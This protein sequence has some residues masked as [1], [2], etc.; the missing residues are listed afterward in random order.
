MSNHVHI[1][2]KSGPDGLSQ[3]MRKLLT[4]YAICYNRRHQRCG[5][6]FQNRY[7]SI[8]CQESAYFQRLVSYIHLNPLRARLVKSIAE[9]DR[10]PWSGHSV[11]M[12]AQRN[13]WQERE[14]VLSQFGRTKR[15]ACKQYRHFLE[16][17]SLKGGQADLIG[18]GLIRS[19]GGWSEVKSH[20]RNEE[21][22]AFDERILGDG[23]FVESV[24]S[25]SKSDLKTDYEIRTRKEDAVRKIKEA[26]EERKVCLDHLRSGSRRP[27]VSALRKELAL[28]LVNEYGYS[29][30]SR[31]DSLAYRLQAFMA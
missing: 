17:E 30:Q 26:C 4:G 11:L 29:L 7:K 18:G 14:Y 24:L 2:L 25:Q 12:N 27:Q 31:H 1:L 10:Y 5:H 13:D 8:I 20:Y 22:Q 23:D 21:K 15:E 19:L 6:L 9:L 3:F 16:L 28:L